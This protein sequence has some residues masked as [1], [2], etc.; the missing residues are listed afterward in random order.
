MIPKNH[1]SDID[2]LRALAVLL[3]MLFHAGI[4]FPGGYIGVDVFF[5]ISGYLITGLIVRDLEIGRFRFLDFLARRIRRLLPAASAMVLTSLFTGMLILLPPALKD[6]G[7]Q[8]SSSAVILANVFFWKNVGYFAGAAD[9]KVLLHTWS[10]SVE[11]QFYLILPVALAIA[12]K[13]WPKRRPV[14]GAMLAMGI[15]SFVLN[16]VLTRLQPTA[17]FYLV[18]PRSWELLMGGCLAL[19]PAPQLKQR[20]LSEILAIAGL[21]AI[22]LPACLFTRGTV[23]PGFWALAPCTGAALLLWLAGTNSSVVCNG[24]GRRELG[25][26][27]RISY[28]VYLW[29]WPILVFVR[30]I[31]DRP[32]GVL[33][34]SACLIMSLLLGAASWR[35]IEEPFRHGT[36]LVTRGWAFGFA[37]FSL[38][39]VLS[40]SWLSR[41]NNGLESRFPNEAVVYARAEAE[42]AAFPRTMSPSDVASRKVHIL[43]SQTN[44]GQ[45]DLI[46]WGDSHAMAVMPSLE[47]WCS[48]NRLNG[49]ALVR[50]STAPLATEHQPLRSR[51]FNEAALRYIRESRAQQ[52]VLVSRWSS[53]YR[54]PNGV[55]FRQA[56][57]D[58]VSQLQKVGVRVVFVREVPDQHM[59]VPKRLALAVSRRSSFMPTGVSLRDHAAFVSAE[60]ELIPALQTLGA[61]ILDP[62]DVLSLPDGNSMIAADGRSLYVDSHHLSRIGSERLLP[63]FATALS[64]EPA[65]KR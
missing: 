30:Y 20:W 63:L 8:A 42:L 32:L 22:V 25:F 19:L 17:A 13:I 49:V 29:H 37:G 11:E 65:R 23:F 50:A 7:F 57:L 1:R 39:V 43:N 51:Q 16:I 59:M 64:P 26:L 9:D 33:E 44:T 14:L 5:T 21:A 35:W 28:S 27:G 60:S 61:T 4:G 10:L 62:L 15:A 34:G 58:T 36:V 47:Q 6:L 38:L 40:V 53:Y 45:V 3:V 46:L 18:P 54:G 12:W 55:H 24:L 52:V 2:G 31:L 41:L 56:L 48:S